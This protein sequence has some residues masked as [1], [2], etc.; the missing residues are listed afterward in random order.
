MTT[1]RVRIRARP[2][3]G[4]IGVA[5]L[6]VALVLAATAHAR[7]VEA[8][9]GVYERAVRSVVVVL[10]EWPA[11]DRP[12]EAP[13]GSG[14]VWRDGRHVVTALHVVGKATAIRIRR[15]DGE[16][17]VA[18]LKAAD[19]ATDVAVLEIEG[20]AGLT[21]LPWTTRQPALG[22]RVCAAGNA[23]G[24]G[25]SLTCGVVSAIGRAGVGFNPVEDFVQTDAA[26]NP[27]ASGGALL[28]G[29]GEV[30]GLLSAIFTKTS[31]ANIGVNFA[32]ST[33]LIERV[34]PDL[35]AHGRVRRVR[36]GL[37]L[38]APGQGGTPRAP[39]VEVRG[40]V[41]G[42]PAALAGVEPGDMVV[43]VGARRIAK[44]QEFIA[45]EMLAVVPG[46]LALDVVRARSRVGLKLRLDVQG[47]AN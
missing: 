47:A 18:R 46:E 26:V 4:R 34:V 14:V 22:E 3:A 43:A 40:V 30:V 36:T 29:N 2:H 9:Q 27:G 17:F 44:V 20:E 28:D 6:V 38:A 5:C 41:P 11:A 8:T 19:P 42:S 25:V 21:P 37:L 12:R 16:L 45:E 39:G 13:E 33:R 1:R 32:C 24:L 10:P 23:F 35:V 15:D 31:D 7:T